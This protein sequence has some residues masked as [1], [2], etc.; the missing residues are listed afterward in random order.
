MEAHRGHVTAEEF[1]IFA[2]AVHCVIDRYMRVRETLA[3]IARKREQE[4]NKFKLEAERRKV[5]TL[6]CGCGIPHNVLFRFLLKM[7]E[8]AKAAVYEAQRRDALLKLQQEMVKARSDPHL[9]DDA[10]S[11]FHIHIIVKVNIDVDVFYSMFYSNT[12]IFFFC[13]VASCHP[14]GLLLYL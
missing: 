3:E 14:S 4:K 7:E 1:G 11:K 10:W 9:A 2:V 6:A 13:C 8:N 12:L 5:N